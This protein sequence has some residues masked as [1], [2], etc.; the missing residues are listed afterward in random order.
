[1]L[2]VDLDPG[3][4]HDHRWRAAAERDPPARAAVRHL[5]PR[6]VSGLNLKLNGALTVQAS[7]NGTE[8]GSA[9]VT[10]VWDPVLVGPA[11]DQRRRQPGRLL[12]RTSTRCP[13][14]FGTHTGA[15]DA[16]VLTRASGATSRRAAVGARI[17]NITDGSSC[18]VASFTATTLTCSEPLAG[19]TENDW[20]TDD[21]YRLRVGSPLAMLEVL[22]DNL[23]QII[24]AIDNISGGGLGEAL[25]TKLPLVGVSPRSCSPNCRT[26][27][28]PSRRSAAPAPACAAGPSDI[29][30]RHPATPSKLTIAGRRVGD[31]LLQRVQPEGRRL[32]RRGARRPCSRLRASPAA[33]TANATDVATAGTAPTHQR[34]D[35][36]HQHRRLDRRAVPAQP[37]GERRRHHDDDRVPDPRRRSPTST[38][39][40]PR[41]TRA[42]PS[43]PRSRRWRTRS[44]TS[45]ASARAST[46]TSTTPPCPGTNLV[47]ARRRH[48]PL[49]RRRARARGAANMPAL[50]TPD[51]RR[52]SRAS[53]I[54]SR[55][56]R[57]ATSDRQLQRRRPASSSASTSTT[58]P[59][60]CT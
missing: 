15:N 45:S 30:P 8:I 3:R 24:A 46:S 43:R 39:S 16:A 25:D 38:A 33:V 7:L 48:R 50:S 37:A 35:H 20:D 32:G 49:Q 9:G 42:S 57:P 36:V 29:T 23:D 2:A 58:T 11:G 17:E 47:T 5:Q 53:A 18:E 34:G 60:R 44:R 52:A 19:G 4:S 12:R 6:D 10:V 27:A 56:A 31:D 1:M 21:L 14:L 26:C 13:N 51:Q 59:R 40:T 22:L 54:S 28:A 41:S 55:R